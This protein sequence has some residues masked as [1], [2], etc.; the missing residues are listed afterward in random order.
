MAGAG[1]AL[2]AEVG[3][4]RVEAIEVAGPGI[5]SRLG[6]RWRDRAERYGLVPVA[7][8]DFHANDR[9]GHC[10]PRALARTARTK[11]QPLIH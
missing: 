3:N 1:E 6:R 5:S 10:E 8:S 7:G 4:H 11:W 2:D 9:P